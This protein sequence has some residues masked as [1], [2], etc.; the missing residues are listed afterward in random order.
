MAFFLNDLLSIKINKFKATTKNVSLKSRGTNH[1]RLDE[2]RLCYYYKCCILIIRLDRL[3]RL[4]GHILF[5]GQF[6]HAS[7][8]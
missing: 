8:N 4:T 5:T 6:A 7:S 3:E 2:I 1:K